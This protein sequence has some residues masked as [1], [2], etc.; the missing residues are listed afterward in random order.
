[1]TADLAKLGHAIR[2]FPLLARC[3]GVVFLGKLFLDVFLGDIDALLGDEGLESAVDTGAANC[4][5]RHV[6][7]DLIGLAVVVEE[8]FLQRSALLLEA[9]HHLAADVLANEVH[10][11]LRNVAHKAISERVNRTLHHKARELCLLVLID[12]VAHLLAHILGIH[13]AHL[14]RELVTDFGNNLAAEF[15]DL[16]I[17]VQLAIA[18][19]RVALVVFRLEVELEGIAELAADKMLVKRRGHGA[20]TQLDHARCIAKA[21]H[22]IAVLRDRH[23]SRDHV[24]HFRNVIGIVNLLEGMVD[25]LEVLKLALD[26]RVGRLVGR[27]LDGNAVVA[28]KLHLRHHG[29]RD[30]ERERLPLDN[31]VINVE[32][33][34]PYEDHVRIV[35]RLEGLF[36]DEHL[37]DAAHG[38]LVAANVLFENRAR[39]LALAEPRNIALSDFSEELVCRFLHFVGGRNQG[40][41]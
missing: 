39:R 3:D 7:L 5:L 14:S 18:E 37:G 10:I 1:M 8:P 9:L 32:I 20:R 41:N 12:L 30:G 11:V 13:A 36:V 35:K 23:S 21:V 31:V 29:A 26:F 34:L 28:R 25:I 4:L 22:G 15:L 33:R 17:G 40:Q 16:D 27:H 2:L 38:V 19:L 6:L 24:A